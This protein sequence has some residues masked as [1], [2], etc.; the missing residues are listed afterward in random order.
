M[1]AKLIYQFVG[2]VRAD[3]CGR[4]LGARV[5][6]HYFWDSAPVQCFRRRTTAVSHRRRLGAVTCQFVGPMLPVLC[7][8]CDLW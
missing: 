5:C 3:A 1:A 7:G 6:W 2:K 8:G 4:K